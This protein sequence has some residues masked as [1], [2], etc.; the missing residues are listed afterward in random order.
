MCNAE[1]KE[2]MRIQGVRQWQI[3]EYIGMNESLLSRKMRRELDPDLKTL[4]NE[5]LDNLGTAPGYGKFH[6]F[7]NHAINK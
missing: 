7:E 3:A 4:V 6:N 1:I 2:R 5:A